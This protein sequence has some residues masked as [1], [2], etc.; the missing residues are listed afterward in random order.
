MR[1]I[2]LSLAV[3]A[4]FGVTAC[5]HASTIT[6]LSENFD[7]LTDGGSATS[8]GAFSTINGTN[9]DIVGP[10]FFPTLC[11]SPESGSCI[12]M[13][14]TN[15]NPIGQLESNSMFAAGTYDLSFDLIGNQ[16]GSSASTTVTFGNYDQE[17]TLTSGDVT[18]GIV[19]NEL[20]TLTTPGYLEFA[21]DDPAGDQEGNLLDDVVVAPAN[22][23]P[24]PTPEPSSLLLMASGLAAGL[25]IVTRRRHLLS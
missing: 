10:G 4:L 16:R 2:S 18:D 5:L 6:S 21:S 17:F 8:A 23:S 13:D 12:D 14:G 11:V 9:V 22:I 24:S 15:G 25:G 19:V 7:E 1:L 20:V 3:A